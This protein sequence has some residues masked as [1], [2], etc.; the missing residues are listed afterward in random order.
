MC[1]V[2][3]DGGMRPRSEMQV[4]GFNCDGTLEQRVDGERRGGGLLGELHG[5]VYRHRPRRA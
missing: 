1:T 3:A 4:G 5:A 2:H